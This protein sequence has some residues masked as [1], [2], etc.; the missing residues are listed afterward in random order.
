MAESH[1]CGAC[2]AGGLGL[3][4][5]I[6]HRPANIQRPACNTQFRT[7]HTLDSA[8]QEDHYVKVMVADS[9]AVTYLLAGAQQRWHVSNGN[10]NTCSSS[11]GGPSEI[12]QGLQIAV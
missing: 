8:A 10:L 9:S 7:R 12:K 2:S 4:R 5:H 1:L 11:D 3:L 6:R